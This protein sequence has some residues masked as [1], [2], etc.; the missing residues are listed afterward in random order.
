MTISSSDT[1]ETARKIQAQWLQS[2]ASI[3][4]NVI[5]DAIGVSA[6]TISRFCS[7]PDHMERA[8]L[9]LAAAGLKVVPEGVKC[10]SHRT[11]Q[12]YKHLAAEYMRQHVEPGILNWDE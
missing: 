8:C 5:A 6:P 2:V 10:V 11:M 7:E 4:Q 3:G 9:V 12:A 1:R